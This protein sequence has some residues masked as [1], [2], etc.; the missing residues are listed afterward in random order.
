MTEN[1]CL[2]LKTS[3]INSNDGQATY[4][5]AT[6]S[7]EKGKIFDNRTGYTW[8]NVN[9]KN[10]LG[11]WYNKYDKFNI[12][13]VSVNQSYQAAQYTNNV[14]QY[15]SNYVVSVKMSGLQWLSS[16]DQASKNNTD[17]Q[18]VG[19]RNFNESNNVI[20]NNYITFLK[21]SQI[22][23]ITINLH[24]LTGD[25]SLVSAQASTFGHM[26]FLFNITPIKD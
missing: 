3:D 18:I 15:S 5:N 25:A 20:G 14:L 7:N 13:L 22:T 12:C 24:S 6:V 21:G 26:T 19:V 2:V 8:Y 16:Y 11:D 9:M 23:N 1:I 17:I 4:F 10:L